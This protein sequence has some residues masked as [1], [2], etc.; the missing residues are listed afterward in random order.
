[1][2]ESPFDKT[3]G[4]LIMRVQEIVTPHR[5]KRYVVIDDSGNLVVPIVRYL[6][7]LDAIGRARNTLRAYAQGLSLYFTYLAQQDLNY[8][9]VTLD[10]LGGF[11]RL[12]SRIHIDHSRCFLYSPWSRHALIA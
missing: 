4:T 7:Y 6:K 12:R 5:Q 9:H 3:G 2:E 1:M 8:Q 11:V 10:D